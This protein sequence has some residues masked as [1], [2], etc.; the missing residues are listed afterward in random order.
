VPAPPGPP[1]GLPL[2]Q[3]QFLTGCREHIHYK[4][5]LYL[6]F[7]N[8]G[9]KTLVIGPQTAWKDDLLHVSTVL[10]H[11]W[12]LEG[13]RSHRNNDWVAEANLVFVPPGRRVRTWVGLPLGATKLDVDTHV[14]QHRA[15]AL[16][17]QVAWENRVE[18]VI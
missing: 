13:P 7:V 16:L 15:G 8:D 4:R 14:R 3:G 6:V 17:A 10:E 1:S 11:V 12:Q 18:L 5:K 2:G 9:A